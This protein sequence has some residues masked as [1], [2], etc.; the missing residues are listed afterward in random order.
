MVMLQ[1]EADSMAR[2]FHPAASGEGENVSV[3]FWE[4][5]GRENTGQG[6]ASRGL[7]GTCDLLVN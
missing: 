3:C 5:G 7:M 2:S 4:Q 1:R 6:R